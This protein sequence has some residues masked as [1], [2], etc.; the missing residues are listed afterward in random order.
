MNKNLASRVKMVKCK[1]CNIKFPSVDSKWS[2]KFYY[3]NC[4]IEW[5]KRNPNYTIKKQVF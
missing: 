1:G 2:K 5:L 4:R 3:K